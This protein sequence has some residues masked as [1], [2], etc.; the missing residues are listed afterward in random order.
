MPRTPAKVSQAD[1]ARVLRAIKA[2]D[3]QVRVEIEDGKIR[4]EPVNSTAGKVDI[5]K[6]WVP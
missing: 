2:A 4:L 3:V 6:V 5:Q 1:I